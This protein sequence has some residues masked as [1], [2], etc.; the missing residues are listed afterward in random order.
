MR[1]LILIL[2]ILCTHALAQSSSSTSSA[3]S[4]IG[5]SSVSS[6]SAGIFDLRFSWKI[7]TE[8]EDGTPFTASEILGYE[9]RY[10]RTTDTEYRYIP[11]PPTITKYQINKLKYDDYQIEIAVYDVNGLYSKYAAVNFTR[12]PN[13]VSN[14]L[15]KQSTVR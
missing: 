7:P 14:L 15:I 2:A 6:S 5:S 9:V 8:R 3:Q 1:Y 10:K 11:L 12:P 13:P 4:S